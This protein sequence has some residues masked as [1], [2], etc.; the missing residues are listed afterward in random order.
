[1]R[2]FLSPKPS[3]VVPDRYIHP[4]RRLRSRSVLILFVVCVVLLP[5]D[6]ARVRDMRVMKEKTLNVQLVF[7][8]SLSMALQDIPP[9]RFHA[10]R[11]SVVSLVS[12]LP[13][14]NLSLI[15]FSGKPFVYMPFS[16]D[17][18][19]LTKKMEQTVL[20]DFP[21]TSDFAGTAIGD[22]LLLSIK[23]LQTASKTV[24]GTGKNGIVVLLTDGD[25][26]K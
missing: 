9:S 15:A 4:G 25:S 22:A 12:H 13:G 16:T 20:A 21:P 19:A 1:M 8:V 14:Y 7:D 26:N 10:A 11:D 24:D 6:I 3:F 17:T 23:N 5:S 18:S 2:F